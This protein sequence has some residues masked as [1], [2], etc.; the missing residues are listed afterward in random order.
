M[1]P[2]SHE[3]GKLLAWGSDIEPATI[4]QAARR[5][6]QLMTTQNAEYVRQLRTLA[7]SVLEAVQR[8]ED[9][10]SMT[11]IEESQVVLST[12]RSA[13][14]QVWT[15]VDCVGSVSVEQEDL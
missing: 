5:E 15:L 14:E 1:S 11:H 8:L 2:T 10:S 13:D 4:E 7:Q 3:N 12:L 6:E 9:L